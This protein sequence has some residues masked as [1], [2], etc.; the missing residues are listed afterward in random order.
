MVSVTEKRTTT[1]F[2]FVFSL[3][4]SLTIFPRVLRSFCTF[5]AS[6]VS[7]LR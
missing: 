5:V 2:D 6:S 4:H 3:A 1:V 7:R